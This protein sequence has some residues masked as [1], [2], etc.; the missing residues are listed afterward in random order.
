S[1]GARRPRAVPAR[2]DTAARAGGNEAGAAA[3]SPPEG[4]K[5]R[6]EEDPM[7]K[8]IIA[9]CA[10]VLAAPLGLAVSPTVAQAQSI[11]LEFG[12]H[13]GLYIDGPRAWYNGHRGY[14]HHRHG[15]R[16]HRG[17]WF[18]PT[19]FEVVRPPYER[20]YYRDRPRRLGSRHV[21]WCYDRYRSYRASD[22][23]YQPYNGPRR[24]CYSPYS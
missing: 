16:Y 3:V 19:A 4:P 13:P 20:G 12:R 24:Q 9:L 15:Y 6:F 22:N 8:I 14:R 17:W 21:E 10:A 7:K 23:T 18:P 11:T 1:A 2:P 5:Q